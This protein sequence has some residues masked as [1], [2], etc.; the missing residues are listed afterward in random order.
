MGSTPSTPERFPCPAPPD[1]DHADDEH[2]EGCGCWRC[3][4]EPAYRADDEA[5]DIA[6]QIAVV[7]RVA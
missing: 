4:D 5:D 1:D 7:R 2:E 3:D 6:Q